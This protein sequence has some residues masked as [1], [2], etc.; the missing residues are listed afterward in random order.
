MKIKVNI[1]FALLLLLS[2]V[3]FSCSNKVRQ[4]NQGRNSSQEQEGS[5]HLMQ[6]TSNTPPDELLIQAQAYYDLGEYRKS[7]SKFNLL[8]EQYPNSEEALS[9]QDFSDELDVKLQEVFLLEKKKRN[10]SLRKERQK[11]LPKS[12]EKIKTVVKNGI[13]IYLDKSSPDFDHKE[14]VYVYF[15]KTRNRPLLHLKMRYVASQWLNIENYIVTVDKQDYTITEKP[16][17]EETKGKKRLFHEILDIPIITS[18][19]M[20][21]VREIAY[22]SNTSIVYVGASEYKKVDLSE[23]Q[24]R[25]FRNV[26]DA[27]EYYGGNLFEKEDLIP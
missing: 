19:T 6:K 24:I 16:V 3:V 23:E 25:A 14:C 2:F 27:Y 9:S 17:K 13:P 7:S 4:S 15:S 21:I 12:K 5:L 8:L 20:D 10:D 26:L 1:F 18:K 11:R 22:G